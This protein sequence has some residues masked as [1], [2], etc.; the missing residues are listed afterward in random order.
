MI[1]VDR[2]AFSRDYGCT[3][4]EWLGWMPRA[5]QGL[6]W[7]V[8]DSAGRAFHSSGP[9]PDVGSMQIDFPDEASTN[10]SGHLSITWAV[11]EPRRIAL[12]VLPRLRVSFQFQ[13]V[14][15]PQRLA[16]MR[17]FDLHLQRG[18]G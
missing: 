2:E 4:S 8:F 5:T 9:A 1:D 13:D 11:Q 18:G 6:A 14:P 17:T 7:R 12:V 16:F 15:L 10:P 3:P